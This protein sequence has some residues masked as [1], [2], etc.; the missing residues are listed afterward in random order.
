MTSGWRWSSL[1]RTLIKLSNPKDEAFVV[2]FSWEA[3]IDQDFY[4]GDRTQPEGRV[5]VHPVERR[6]G[7]AERGTF[8]ADC[9]SK[10]AKQPKQV[11]L[12]ITD[13]EDYASSATL[14]QA[15]RRIQDLDGPTI[16][17][18]GLL[19]GEDTNKSESRHAKRVLE[20]LAE[21]TGGVAYFP[22]T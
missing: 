22:R 11:L 18:V 12:V 16:Y 9:L 3:F 1:R 4:F 5:G 13:G 17:C 7:D 6:D 14:E 21:Q 2:D 19:F 20:A 15:I 10:N 8:L